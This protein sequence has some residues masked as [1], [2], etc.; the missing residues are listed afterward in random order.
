MKKKIILIIISIIIAA[1]LLLKAKKLIGS[2]DEYV[3]ATLKKAKIIKIIEAS[4]TIN[5]VQTATCGAQVAG[6][7]TGVY[8]DFNSPVTKGQLLA[9]ID[10]SLFQASVDQQ[11]ASIENSKAQLRRLEATTNYDKLMYE[12]YKNLLKKGYVSKAEVDQLEATYLADVANIQAQ[13]AQIKQS[14]ASLR[15]AESNLGYTKIISPVDGVIISKNV[16]VGETVASSFQTPE[17]F[18]VAEDLTEMQIEANVSEADIGNVSVGQEAD[19]TLDGY[20]NE[21]FK[22]HV[23]QVR[24]SST[25]TSNVV[26]YTV[27]ISVKNEDLKLKPGMT[28][29]VSIVVD[30]KENILTAI[31]PALKFT[32]LGKD[33]KYDTQGIW[34]LK[35]NK[36][37]RVD[38]QTGVYDDSKTEI[39]SNELKEGD[40]V[41]IGRKGMETST[42]KG[43][44]PPRFL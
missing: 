34:V 5:P 35:N 24:L 30:K 44:R 19:Y 2:K 21:T 7:I 36:P 15:T 23:D 40:M 39:I 27:V 9:E 42:A 32:L 13:K 37:T 17:L 28:A 3:T 43:M 20:P 16:E 18:S 41:I 22:G 6:K 12:R 29:N 8:V 31:N 1:L 33:V 25:N 4:G 26:T 11:R 38:I 14:E 10:T